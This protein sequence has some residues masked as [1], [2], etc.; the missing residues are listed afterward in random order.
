MKF[1]FS[2]QLQQTNSVLASLL[3]QFLVV[4]F[5]INSD[6][7]ED[8]SPTEAFEPICRKWLKI[9]AVTG[10]V[11]CMWPQGEI[12]A[13]KLQNLVFKQ[14]DPEESWESHPCEVVSSYGKQFYAWVLLKLVMTRKAGFAVILILAGL[15][16]LPILLVAVF[17][18]LS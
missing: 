4:K 14:V 15:A 3:L 6:D 10:A 13:A 11:E 5:L 9:N 16:R 17:F 18:L 12:T 2:C 1:V 8:E 7:D